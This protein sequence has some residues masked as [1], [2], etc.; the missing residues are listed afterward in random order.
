M[1]V[2]L[3]CNKGSVG[4]VGTVFLIKLHFFVS[5]FI[6]KFTIYC[7]HVLESVVVVVA[8]V[9]VVVVVVAGFCVCAVVVAVAVFVDVVVVVVVVVVVAAA[10]VL[11]S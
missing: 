6:L 4:F 10:A 8:A 9:V 7:A 2:R 5:F 1:W 11:C 3:A